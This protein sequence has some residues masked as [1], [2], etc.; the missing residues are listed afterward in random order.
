MAT[1]RE[2]A[3]FRS[4]YST[5]DH[6][7]VVRQLTEKCG[8]FQIP[9]CLAFVDY[10][11]AFDSVEANAVFN[12][13]NRFGINVNYVDLLEELN[14][15]CSTEIKLFNDPCHIKICKGVRQGDTISPK[16]F[17][18][19]LEALFGSLNWRHQNRRRKSHAFAFCGRLRHFCTRRSRA[20]EQAG[21]TSECLKGDWTRD[22]PLLEMNKRN[23]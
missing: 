14:D 13:L 15:G 12:A 16:L 2:Q 17:A 10:K 23:G 18:I 9:L 8:E 11:K 6:L 5:M 1:S 19:T 3:G 7:H 21:S 22:E 20:S 4:G